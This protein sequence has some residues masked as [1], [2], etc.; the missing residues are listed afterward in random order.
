MKKIKKIGILSVLGASLLLSGCSSDEFYDEVPQV[1][2]KAGNET[3][4][5]VIKTIVWRAEPIHIGQPKSFV[6]IL[7]VKPNSTATIDLT[8]FPID[9]SKIKVKNLDKSNEKKDVKE[10]NVVNREL[11][12]I[13]IGVGEKTESFQIT[14]YFSPA[15][16]AP[17]YSFKTIVEL[18]PKKPS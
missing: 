2:I 17:D 14:F 10:Y 7:N 6:N 8:Q 12:K 1:A 16:L 11:N 5:L 15:L 3:K 18:I 4:Q 9:I 13:E